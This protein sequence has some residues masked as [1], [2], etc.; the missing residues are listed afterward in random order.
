LRLSRDLESKIAAV[1]LNREVTMVISALK[2]S[3]RRRNRVDVYINGKK[4]FSILKSVATGLVVGQELSFDDIQLLKDKDLEERNYQYAL[5]LIARRPHSEREL[6]DRFLRRD[7]PPGV[8]D[9][10]V[11]RLG[12][13][14]LVD[15]FSF[16]QAWVENRQTFRPRSAWALKYEMR[17][18]GVPDRAIQAALEEFDEEDAAFRAGS[19]AARKFSDLPREEFKRRL[20]NFLRRRGFQYSTISPIVK[21]IWSET[22]GNGGESEDSK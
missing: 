6:R 22:T 14:G 11:K 5:N 15:D 18:K 8:Q 16:A 1:Y 17:Q 13:Q 10:V 3:K 4:D 12:E 19:K 2:L 9:R 21:R 7:V 20:S